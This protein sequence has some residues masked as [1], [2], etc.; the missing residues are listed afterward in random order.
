MVGC[1]TSNLCLVESLGLT[2]RNNFS[3]SAW[4]A[5]KLAGMV[6]GDCCGE[7]SKMLR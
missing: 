4:R 1:C 6:R 7:L 2:S 5:F 3:N